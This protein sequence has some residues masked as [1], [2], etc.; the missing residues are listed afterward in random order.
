MALIRASIDGSLF[1]G[2][3]WDSANRFRTVSIR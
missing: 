2:S 1:Y 3:V